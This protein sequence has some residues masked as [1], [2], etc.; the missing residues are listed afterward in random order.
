MTDT[1][2][3]A[4]GTK[5]SRPRTAGAP[6]GL[7]VSI[8]RTTCP[9]WVTASSTLPGRPPR[10]NVTTVTVPSS[11]APSS[12]RPPVGRRQMTRRSRRRART[13]R[14]RPSRRRRSPRRPGARR[15]ACANVHFAPP[16]SGS[17]MSL[18]A[19][20]VTP[21][22]TSAAA[23]IGARRRAA[24]RARSRAPPSSCQSV[25]NRLSRVCPPPHAARRARARRAA[26]PAP[27]E[28]V[29]APLGRRPGRAAR[30]QHGLVDGLLHALRPRR[31]PL[32]PAR[33]AGTGSPRRCRARARG[34][35]SSPSS[36]SPTSVAGRKST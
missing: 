3:P 22:T 31:R 32:A 29:T 27:S 13:P 19:F 34:R 26:R 9:S 21:T 11:P 1:Y 35:R 24:R 8:C 7:S 16:P 2:W 14:R 12:G 15:A 25:E 10:R 17:P 36:S 18:S 28:R 23:G 5:A 30:R 4:H 20:P 6:S 33:R